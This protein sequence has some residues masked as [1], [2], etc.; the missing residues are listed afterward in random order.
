VTREKRASA[1]GLVTTGRT[2]SLSRAFE[3]EQHFVQ[4]S[5]DRGFVVDCYGFIDTCNPGRADPPYV[6]TD[7][8]KAS[9]PL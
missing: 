3:P 4:I 8:S 9:R 6:P 1:A 2:V 7:R 5:P